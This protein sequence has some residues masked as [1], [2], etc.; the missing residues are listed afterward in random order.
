MSAR[1]VSAMHL[2]AIGCLGLAGALAWAPIA[3]AAPQPPGCADAIE[4][5]EEV[6]C[7]LVLQKGKRAPF[8]GVLLS[9][10]KSKQIQA[11]QAVLEKALEE[12]KKLT[13][14]ARAERDSARLE[15]KQVVTDLLQ[16]GQRLERANADLIKS[17]AALDQS[18]RNLEDALDKVPTNLTLI[19][20]GTLIAVAAFG[21][22]YGIGKLF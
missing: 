9:P 5:G 1:T 15:S 18:N 4:R 22:G 16:S 21:A 14:S 20:G 2:H 11:D 13:A 6:A 12:Q 19:L 10:V 17:S 7:Q 3:A 8:R